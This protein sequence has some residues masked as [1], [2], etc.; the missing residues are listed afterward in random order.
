[1]GELSAARNRDR[2]LFEGLAGASVVILAAAVIGGKTGIIRP[3]IAQLVADSSFSVAAMSGCLLQIIRFFRGLEH[4]DPGDVLFATAT[5]LLIVLTMA[6]RNG[7]V[8]FEPAVLVSVWLIRWGAG[9][10]FDA[11]R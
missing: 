10:L 4:K 5:F 6:F 9:L 8:A 1:M 3:D 7:V 11:V 2:A